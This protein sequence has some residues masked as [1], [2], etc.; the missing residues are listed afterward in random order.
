M[1]VITVKATNLV[2]IEEKQVPKPGPEEFLVKNMVS[3]ISSGTE[4]SLYKGTHEGFKTGRYKYPMSIG[5]MCAG[6]VVEAG[7]KVENIKV[8]YRVASTMPH[9]EYVVL[10]NKSLFAKLPDNVSYDDAVFITNATTAVNCLHRAAP[11]MGDTVAVMGQGLLGMLA[12]QC[13]K[14]SGC[15]TIAIDPIVQRLNIA[16]EVGADYALSPLDPDF[17]EK[18]SAANDGKKIDIVIE[19]SGNANALKQ[20][21]EIVKT[22]GKMVILARHHDILPFNILGE[23]FFMKELNVMSSSVWGPWI[24]ESTDYLKWTYREN[25]KL[26]ANLIFQKKII[27]KPMITHYF[28]S[29]KIKDVYELVEKQGNTVLQVILNWKE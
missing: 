16:E 12:L 11:A 10:N 2:E 4:L 25:Y 23:H 19:A 22:Q 1:K 18:L 9:A 27:T 29:S 7:N 26:A 17:K 15:K 14:T 8:G 20:G 28:P 13:A 24:E 5:Y 3:G 21:L 6:E